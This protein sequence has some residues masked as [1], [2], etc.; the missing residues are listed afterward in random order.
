MFNDC[1]CFIFPHGVLFFLVFFSKKRADFD[2]PLLC[3]VSE[4]PASQK[5]ALFHCEVGHGVGCL[6]RWWLLNAGASNIQLGRTVG[7]LLPQVCSA[8][9]MHCWT[10]MQCSHLTGVQAAIPEPCQLIEESFPK[11]WNTRIYYN[12]HLH[13]WRCGSSQIIS[14]SVSQ[15]GLRNL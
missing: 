15:G 7:N 13:L 4:E 11:F 3:I 12:C 9:T 8:S 5:P 10:S 2:P 1:F 14:P 6:G